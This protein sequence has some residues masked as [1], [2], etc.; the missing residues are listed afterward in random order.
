MVA[1]VIRRVVRAAAGVV[2]AT[3]LFAH[4]GQA[5][6]VAQFAANPA[7]VL[8]QFPNGGPQLISLVRDA[9]TQNPGLLQTLTGLL[10]GASAD[11]QAAIGSGLGQAAQI[12]INNN[13]QAFANQISAAVAASGASNA[14]TAFSGAT[15]N[16]QTAA[17][18]AGAGAGG[19]G[20]GGGGSGGPAGGSGTGSGGG[21][22]SGGSN[23]G[24]TTT[25]SGGGS[26]QTST[27]TF[28]GGGGGAGSGSSVSPR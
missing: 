9:V 26:T 2:M 7:Q 1:T 10:Q 19:G 14:Q 22:P 25:G 17:T 18:G 11:Q 28:T 3:M 23:S 4:P 15:G 6:T 16:T 8:A 5:Q 27:S 24:G 13:N 20:G 21:A 12:A